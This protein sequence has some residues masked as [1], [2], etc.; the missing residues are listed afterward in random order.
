MTK[1]PVHIEIDGTTPETEKK[2][3]VQDLPSAEQHVQ[4][5][6]GQGSAMAPSLYAKIHASGTTATSEEE[7][8]ENKTVAQVTPCQQAEQHQDNIQPDKDAQNKV[9]PAILLSKLEKDVS[10]KHK[11]AMNDEPEYEGSGEQV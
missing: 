10:E 9:I 8:T 11:P 5:P 1:S 6:T 3:T 4:H 2:K 7:P